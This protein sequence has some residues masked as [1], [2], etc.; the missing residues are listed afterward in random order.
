M[1]WLSTANFIPTST[2]LDAIG[3]LIYAPL[4]LSEA[5]SGIL[6]RSCQCL[7]SRCSCRHTKDQRCRSREASTGHRCPKGSESKVW[8][9]KTF[10]RPVGQ[11]SDETRNR[12][13]AIPFHFIQSSKGVYYCTHHYK[14]FNLMNG[15]REREYNGHQNLSPSL[16]LAHYLIIPTFCKH[17]KGINE[18]LQSS[19]ACRSQRCWTVWT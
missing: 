13:L 10:G 1:V 9:A 4:D 5:E 16:S 18:I 6:D 7:V 17:S 2:E 19:V 11:N 3:T 12:Y 8:Q 15:E 14:Y